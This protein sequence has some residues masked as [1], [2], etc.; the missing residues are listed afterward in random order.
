M[1]DIKVSLTIGLPGRTMFSKQE[2]LKQLTKPVIGKDGKV[3]KNKAGKTM[4][5]VC[6]VTDTSK[7]NFHTLKVCN[8]NGGGEEV[9]E[10]TT[11]KCKPASQV[12]NICTEAY[13]DFISGS[14]PVGYKAPSDFKPYMPVRSYYDEKRHKYIEGLDINVQAWNKASVEAR[15]KWHLNQICESRGGWLEDFTV[16]ED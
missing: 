9:L 10:F 3:R 15:L 2:C 11:R 4:Y 14:M 1:N 6:T 8:P 7:L 12:I 5:K 13:K 16:F